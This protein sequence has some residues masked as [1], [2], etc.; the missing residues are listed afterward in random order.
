MKMQQE[1]KELKDRIAKIE[2]RNKK[3]EADK[4]WELSRTRSIFIAIS[5]YI[6]ISIFM[7]LIK[8]N[9]PFLNALV[10]TC[11]YLLSTGTY[12]VFKKRW[13]KKNHLPEKV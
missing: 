5:T 13:L 8:D 6:L 11:G 3:V 9:H 7:L 10:A 2:S 1:L 4:A 12:D